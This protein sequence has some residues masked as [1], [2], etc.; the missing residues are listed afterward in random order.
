MSPSSR[1]PDVVL[2][3][4]GRIE[5]DVRDA[6]GAPVPDLALEAQS[7]SRVRLELRSD[8]LG[9]ARSAYVPAGLWRAFADAGELGRGNVAFEVGVDEP[10]RAELRLRR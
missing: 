3:P 10:V 5:I 1:L 8:L 6:W 4:M 2:P 9:T 7:D